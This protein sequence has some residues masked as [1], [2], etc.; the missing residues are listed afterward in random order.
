MSENAKPSDAEILSVVQNTQAGLMT[1]V[2]RNILAL[3]PRKEWGATHKQQY[4]KLDTSFIRRRLIALEKAGK[5]RRV[6]SC[7]AV[8]ICWKAA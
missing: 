6:P 3:P 2:V 1:Y 4:R 8:Q 7:Y 5:V